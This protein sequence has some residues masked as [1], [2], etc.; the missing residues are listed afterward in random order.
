MVFDVQGTF[1]VLLFMAFFGQFQYLMSC[2]WL[3]FFS[4]LVGIELYVYSVGFVE[5]L[6]KAGNT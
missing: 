3:P 2:C 5:M 4:P 1:I 6:Q